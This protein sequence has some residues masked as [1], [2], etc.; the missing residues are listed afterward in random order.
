MLIKAAS[1]ARD[2]MKQHSF[3]PY[4]LVS[5]LF[6]ITA[7]SSDGGGAAP[8]AD[9][10]ADTSVPEVADDTSTFDAIID[11]GVDSSIDSAEAEDVALDTAPEA[12]PDAET[13]GDASSDSASSE[14]SAETGSP[15][16]TGTIEEQACGKCGKRYR[17]CDM[18]KWLE[19]GGCGEETGGCTP[20]ET[21][22]VPCE[23]CGTRTQTCSATCEWGGGVCTDQKACVAGT[24]E[25]RYS[26]GGDAGADAGS[27]TRTCT[28]ACAWTDWSACP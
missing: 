6:A 4:T 3:L 26:C 15:C 28:T 24:T 1:V 18:S 14:T 5:V 27:Q 16:V 9:S 13:G 12:A 20:G 19:W 25:T 17:L 23:R 21:R 10:A 7:C 2:H 11:S 8:V 22:D